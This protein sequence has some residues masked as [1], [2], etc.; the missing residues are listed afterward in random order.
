MVSTQE[1]PTKKKLC[2]PKNSVSSLGEDLTTQL[3]QVSQSRGQGYPQKGRATLRH[4]KE[5]DGTR[6]CT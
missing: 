2:G 1:R 3:G 6:F 4:D 5:T